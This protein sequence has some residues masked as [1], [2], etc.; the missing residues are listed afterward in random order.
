MIS[1]KSF[2]IRLPYTSRFF[3][4]WIHEIKGMDT[5]QITNQNRFRAILQQLFITE[6]ESQI[7]LVVLAGITLIAGLVRIFLINQP[8]QY[9][10]AYT[11]IHYGSQPLRT[12]LAN[13]S[14]PNN[15][16]FH[17][18]L[19]S[20]SYWLFGGNLWS[21]RLPAFLAGVLLVPAG[22]V[23]SRK[24]FPPRQALAGASALAVTPLL[25]EYSANGRGYTLLALFSL[26]LTYFAGIL[27][28]RESP[29]ALLAYA[30]TAAFGFYTIP[31]FLYPM[32]GISLWVVGTYIVDDCPRNTRFRKLAFFCIICFLAGLLSFALYSPVIFFG[33]GLKSIVSNEV[34]EPQNWST[35]LANLSPRFMATA[36]NWM[37]GIIPG[38]RTLLVIGFVVSVVYY[39]QVSNQKLPLQVFLVVGAFGTILIQR[40]V[41]LFRVWLYLDVFFMIFSAAGL[42]WATE[43]FV[44]KFKYRK[45]MNIV[46]YSLIVILPCIYLIYSTINFQKALLQVNDVPERNA[47]LYIRENLQS[48]EIII[49]LPPVD[50]QTGYYLAINGIP[51]DRFFQPDHPVDIKKAFVVLRD[52]SKFDTPVKVLRYF[53]LVNKCPQVKSRL[54]YVYGHVKV[55]SLLFVCY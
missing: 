48:D 18:L 5:K 1:Y 29:S 26:L 47:A 8:V 54:V 55:F 31:I 14:A 51:Y 36:Y 42:S 24:F 13:Y 15:H 6:H 53:D 23:S 22:Y 52:N 20:A 10:E 2:V 11:F 45:L 44:S 40:V 9:D 41:P 17:T 33:T 4:G 50:I 7:D 39:R 37:S 21:L 19:L 25:I 28:K 35:F 43:M 34:V 32:A 49:A 16:I 12:I 3:K 38:F 30:V 46:W 27:V